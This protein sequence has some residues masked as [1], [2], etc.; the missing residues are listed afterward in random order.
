MGRSSKWV[1]TRTYHIFS[2]L[3]GVIFH[4]KSY[5]LQ[6]TPSKLDMSFW[7]YDLLKDRQNNRKEK[8]LFPLFGSI[9]KSYLRVL[10]HF[11]WSHHI[12]SIKMQYSKSNS[13][14]ILVAGWYHVF[15]WFQNTEVSLWNLFKMQQLTLFCMLMQG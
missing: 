9:S 12:W 6:K 14:N 3:L 7:S 10:T 13:L 8:D 2:F 1:W 11:A 15:D 4:S 5:V